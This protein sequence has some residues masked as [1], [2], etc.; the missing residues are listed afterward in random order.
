ML[1][2]H[3]GT[4]ARLPAHVPLCG[5]IYK[6]YITNKPKKWG[7]KIFVRA[8][9]SGI[10]YDFLIYGGDDTFRLREVCSSE[11][12]SER[13]ILQQLTDVSNDEQNVAGSANAIS[14]AEY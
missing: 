3:K 9:V 1:V 5:T 2:P 4:R 6:Q 13:E 10:V 7:Y 14:N 11:M 8:S 12:T